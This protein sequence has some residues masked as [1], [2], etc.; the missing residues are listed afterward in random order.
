MVISAN[1]LRPGKT[2]EIE[3]ILFKVIDYNHNKTGRGGAVIKVKIK[4]LNT[5]SIV[6]KLFRPGDKIDDARIETKDMQFLYES[7]GLY[8]F[9][10]NETFEQIDVPLEVLDNAVDYIK[11]GITIGLQVY[12]DK[13]IGASLPPSL[14]LEV[15]YTE[16]GVKGDTVNNVLKPAK[17]ET[18]IEIQVPIF[19]NQGDFV[20]VD[21]RTNSYIERA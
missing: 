19:V 16:P 4:N 18:G 14:V 1:E 5:G 11:D 6:E 3:G 2:I 13:V 20:K 10:D 8:S 21:T 12:N 7:D 17:L 15:V 9:M